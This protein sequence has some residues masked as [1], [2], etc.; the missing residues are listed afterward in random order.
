MK[1][2]TAFSKYEI[3]RIARRPEARLILGVSDSTIWNR[4]KKGGRWYD[5]KFPQPK[6]LGTG[7]RC[8]IGWLVSE[9]LAYIEAQ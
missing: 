1:K 8:A 3:D 7:R 2:I 5:P 4:L 6:R 9:L